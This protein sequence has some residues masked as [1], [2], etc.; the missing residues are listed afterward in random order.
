LIQLLVDENVPISVMEWLRVRGVTA[1]RVSEVGLKG[2]R[3]EEV[4]RHATKN[5]MVILTLDIDF[6]QIY[7][8]VFR[9]LLGIVAIRAKPPTAINIIEMLDKTLRKITLDDFDKKLT[10]ITER[11]VRMI[12]G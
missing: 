4:A 2:A 12:V 8:D 10:I 1:R 9:G 6:A 7:H 5:N 3:D 11:K